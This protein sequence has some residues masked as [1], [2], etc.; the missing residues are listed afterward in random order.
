MLRA[1]TIDDEWPNHI[2]LKRAIEQNG[3]LEVVQQFTH[4][5]MALEKIH[6]LN[7]DV[8]FLD[9]EMPD[10]N[11]LEL[12]EKILAMY[13]QIQIIFVTAYSQYAI[14]AF[15]VNA[16]DYILKPVDGQELN[17]VVRKIVKRTS[18]K[19]PESAKEAHEF[20]PKGK[21]LCLG[22]FEVY[23]KNST[24]KVQWMT[25]K[26]EE[27]LA[28]LIIHLGKPVDKWELCDLLWPH[29]DPEKAIT[30]LHTSIYRLKKSISN[31]QVPLQIKSSSN[32]YWVELEEC[33]IDYQEFERLS[34]DLLRSNQQSTGEKTMTMFMKA[35]KYYRGELFGNKAY[36]WSA[37]R[38][39]GINQMY[40]RLVYRM[41]EYFHKNQLI[42]QELEHLKK[43]LLLFP[44]EEKACILV[45]DIYEKLKDKPAL[46]RIYQQYSQYHLK[47]MG[48]KPS[49]KIEQ[50]Y[51]KLLKTL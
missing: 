6:E 25:A 23:G 13:G 29:L 47:E 5:E 22:D 34:L 43:V 46:M 1:I 39:E 30:N 7:P 21:I 8:A 31:E 40:I 45:M 14:E 28:Y 17:R 2:L 11:G 26:V 10:M 35:E 16:L 32:G 51:E 12:A 50:H 18:Q 38:G 49:L 36:L 19:S 15:K 24:Q 4:P 37:A 33:L 27:L 20:M 44:Y 3:Q 48:C 9:I 41:A 42:E